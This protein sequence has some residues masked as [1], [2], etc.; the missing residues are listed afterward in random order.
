MISVSEDR[1]SE[2][3]RNAINPLHVDTA[4]DNRI[5]KMPDNRPQAL[6]INESSVDRVFSI[7]RMIILELHPIRM[8]V[9][10]IF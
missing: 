3:I 6:P 4:L 2:I 10:N 8:R 5:H 9:H 1:N 7:N